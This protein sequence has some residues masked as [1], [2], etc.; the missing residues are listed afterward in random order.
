MRSYRA[1]K[2][3]KICVYSICYRYRKPFLNECLLELM[4]V[5]QLYVPATAIFLKDWEKGR[6]VGGFEKLRVAK[7]VQQI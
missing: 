5:L 2:S 4:T 6:E 1:Y 3:D 7:L